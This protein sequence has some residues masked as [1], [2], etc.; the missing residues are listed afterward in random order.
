MNDYSLS[1]AIGLFNSVINFILLL[2]ANWGCKKL[3]GSGIY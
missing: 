1:T 3:S 2:T